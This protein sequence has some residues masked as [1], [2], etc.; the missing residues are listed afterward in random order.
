L[1]AGAQM[2]SSQ[3]RE[4]SRV[5]ASKRKT[6]DQLHNEF[7]AYHEA[8]PRVYRLVD[9]FAQEAISRGYYQYAIA[10][11]W[12]RIRWEVTIVNRSN[13]DGADFKMPNNHRAHYARMWLANNPRFNKDDPFFRTAEL[14]SQRGDDFEGDRYGRSI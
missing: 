1:A 14:R 12:E 4:G 9:R 11:I 5:M 7:L 10:T 8:N 3:R 13:I 6:Y 2:R